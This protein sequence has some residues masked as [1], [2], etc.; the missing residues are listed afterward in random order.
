MSAPPPVNKETEKRSRTIKTLL[1]VVAM[2]AILG[3]FSFASL[4][5]RP[6]DMPKNTD[7]IAPLGNPNPY[8]KQCH[9]ADSLPK[10][11][12]QKVQRAECTRCHKQT[13]KAAPASLRKDAGMA[14]QP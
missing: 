9:Q 5:D 11:H 10:T 1:F 13:Q 3:F 8:C 7:H 14:K 4:I 6:L 2:A 12:P